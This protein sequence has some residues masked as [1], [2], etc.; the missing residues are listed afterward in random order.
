MVYHCEE[1]ARRR[2]NP[3]GRGCIP[4]QIA[5][6][7][8][9]LGPAGGRTRGLATAARK[10]P[11]NLRARTLRLPL[12]LVPDPSAPAGEDGLNA[13]EPTHGGLEDASL[14]ADSD[15]VAQAIRD[16]VARRYEMISPIGR[17]PRWRVDLCGKTSCRQ[18]FPIDHVGGARASQWPDRDHPV[19]TV[20]LHPFTAPLDCIAGSGV[21]SLL[22]TGEAEAGSAGEQPTEE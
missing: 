21:A 18:A 6:R 14:S 12:I 1:P 13:Q 19:S 20:G 16:D 2:S 7:S 4:L 10:Y 3:E 11:M 8:F 9:I 17:E 5:S 22:A 15:E